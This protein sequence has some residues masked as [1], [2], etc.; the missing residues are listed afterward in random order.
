[1]LLGGAECC[2]GCEV[3]LWLHGWMVVREGGRF[4]VIVY[5]EVDCKGKERG[6]SVVGWFG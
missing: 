1:M 6:Y 4:G 5:S 3:V 2:V